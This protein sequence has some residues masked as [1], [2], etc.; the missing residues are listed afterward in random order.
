MVDVKRVVPGNVKFANDDAKR[1]RSM[2]DREND[3][4]HE[5]EVQKLKDEHKNEVDILEARHSGM[6]EKIKDLQND[7]ERIRSLRSSDPI[8]NKKIGSK[9]I[10]LDEGVCVKVEGEKITLKLKQIPS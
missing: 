7:L 3:N 6:L 10:V 4:L 8:K 1:N 9:L 5:V 2:Y